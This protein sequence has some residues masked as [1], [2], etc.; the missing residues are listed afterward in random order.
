MTLCTMLLAVPHRANPKRWCIYASFKRAWM[1]RRPTLRNISIQFK[2]LC[3]LSINRP[4]PRRGQ[5]RKP[6]RRT[7]RP[8][9][10]LRLGICSRGRASS[11]SSRPATSARGGTRPRRRPPEACVRPAG[12][13]PPAQ[14]LPLSPATARRR[15]FPVRAVH[16]D[17]LGEVLLANFLLLS[18]KK[19]RVLH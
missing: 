10:A 4:R 19:L 3:K 7:P 12:T 11:S 18:K 17:A 16:G 2:N 8:G 15:R 14:L 9:S 6:A 13:T 5:L 1:E